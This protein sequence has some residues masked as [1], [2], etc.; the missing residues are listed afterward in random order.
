MKDRTRINGVGISSSF[1]VRVRCKYCGSSPTF[2]YSSNGTSARHGTVHDMK[3]ASEFSRNFT[4]VMTSD[5]AY[6]NTH[7]K[8]I[9]IFETA[10]HLYGRAYLPACHHSLRP[11]SS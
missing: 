7:P 2:H 8:Y 10:Y 1:M 11:V 4:N 3:V 6:D 9:R 5:W